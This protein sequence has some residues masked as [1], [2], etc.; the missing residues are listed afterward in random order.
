MDKGRIEDARKRVRLSALVASHT[1]L[2]RAAGG[3]LGLC[4]FHLEKTP[5]FHVSDVRGTFKCF[6][7]GA[8]GDAIDFVM[9]TKGVGFA[10]AV[11]ELLGEDRAGGAA[12]HPFVA[13]RDAS[14]A[15]DDE[16]RRIRHAHDLWLKRL[17]V[18]G[19]LAAAY[20]TRT[21]NIPSKLPDI[22]GYVPDAYCSVL[23]ETTEALIA[24]LQDSEG[25][26]TAVQQ[27]F[28]SSETLDAWRDKDGRRVKRT[29]GAMRDGAVRLALPD[30]V[31]GLAGSV[32]DGLAAMA[33]FS[34]PVWAVCGE[35]RLGRVWVPD[36]IERLV[37]FGDADAAG[38]RFASDARAAHARAGRKIEI[39][40]PET[41]KDWCQVLEG[42]G[43][44]GQRGKGAVAETAA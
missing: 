3:F 34:L 37:I 18:A 41:G 15:R 1:R 12:L 17:P 38:A 36:E 39:A 2:K 29:L 14:G 40:F 26:V 16:V 32:E 28:L 22:L 44:D 33:M 9:L 31:L 25:H 7:C 6:G 24:P 20:L 23:E 35:A 21:R 5:S 4:P 13:A 30:A 8:W 27:V 11:G 43:A 42:R 19:T 10:D